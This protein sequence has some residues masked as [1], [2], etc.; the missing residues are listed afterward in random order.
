MNNGKVCIMVSMKGTPDHTQFS[1]AA[2][3]FMSAISANHKLKL[4][5]RGMRGATLSINSVLNY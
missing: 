5:D 2:L 4:I 3:A 1:G